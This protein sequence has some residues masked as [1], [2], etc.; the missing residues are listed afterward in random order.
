M[1]Y[2]Y[3]TRING[4]KRCWCS[5]EPLTFVAHAFR[6]LRRSPPP[7]RIV[8]L[9]RSSPSQGMTALTATVLQTVK[10]DTQMLSSIQRPITYCS[11]VTTDSIVVKLTSVFLHYR[12]WI[13]TSQPAPSLGEIACRDGRCWLR[14]HSSGAWY[15]ANACQRKGLPL[16]SDKNGGLT[17]TRTLCGGDSAI[18]LRKRHKQKKLP[19]KR[20][21]PTERLNMSTIFHGIT[22]NK[23]WMWA[24]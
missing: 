22:F 21:A 10:K 1:N 6:S 16:F 15:S 20:K 19:L 5:S 11:P 8:M 12:V 23:T 3:D 4:K 13:E 2:V 9:W 14:F 18:F 7:P 24:C 17:I